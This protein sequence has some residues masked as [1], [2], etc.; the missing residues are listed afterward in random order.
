MCTAARCSVDISETD[1]I[2]T[3]AIEA[4]LIGS[5]PIQSDSSGLSE[6]IEPGAALIVP[7]DQPEA[8]ADALTRALTDDALIKRH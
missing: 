3:S 5:V 7:H 6:W 4:M 8:I 1:G 2:A